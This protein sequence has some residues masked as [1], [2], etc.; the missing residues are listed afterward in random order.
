[1]WNPPSPSVSRRYH[2]F[3]RYRRGCYS[4]FYG[5]QVEFYNQLTA[6]SRNLSVRDKGFFNDVAHTFGCKS[7]SRAREVFEKYAPVAFSQN[8]EDWCA[9]GI[10]TYQDYLLRAKRGCIVNDMIGT[11][12]AAIE[13]GDMARFAI[14]NNILPAKTIE[15]YYTVRRARDFERTLDEFQRTIGEWCDEILNE[16]EQKRLSIIW[17]RNRAK[18]EAMERLAEEAKQEWE[19]RIRID[20]IMAEYGLR[21]SRRTASDARRQLRALGIVA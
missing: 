4:R 7:A 19:R 17:E 6:E 14:A 16:R 5:K 18:R 10:L 11:I 3:G 1:M 2:H 21:S 13:M 15:R 20:C 12:G 9:V 8:K